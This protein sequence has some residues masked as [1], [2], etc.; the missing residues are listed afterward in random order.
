MNSY[1]I[2]DF[3][4]KKITTSEAIIIKNSIPNEGEY[5]PNLIALPNSSEI[6][7]FKARIKNYISDLSCDSKGLEDSSWYSL[8]FL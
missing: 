7:C 5:G 2:L 3:Y 4:T 1:T 8:R 6:T